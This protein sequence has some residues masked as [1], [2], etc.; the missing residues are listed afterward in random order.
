MKYSLEA[1]LWGL[2]SITSYVFVKK[3]EKYQNFYDE[4]KAPYLELCF[5]P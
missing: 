1:P 5:S 4:K 3:Q 2:M